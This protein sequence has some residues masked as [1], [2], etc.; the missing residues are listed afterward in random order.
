MLI[1]GQYAYKKAI[2]LTEQRMR[3]LHEVFLNYFDIIKYKAII[4]SGSEIEF[5]GINELVE[6][7]NHRE[8]KIRRIEV[9]CQKKGT[10]NVTMLFIHCH[11]DFFVQYDKTVSCLYSVTDTKE[12]VNL[13]NDIENIFTKARAKYW[14]FSKICT[15]Q[16]IIIWGILSLFHIIL[17]FGEVNQLNYSVAVWISIFSSMIFIVTVLRKILDSFLRFL[18]P[19]IV[20]CWGENHDAN[21]RGVALRSNISWGLLFAVVGAVIG[22]VVTKYLI[23]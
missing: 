8:R 1:K 19:P 16:L 18:F 11:T 4:E 3:D 15:I 13:K 2:I 21:T 10:F 22:G 9:T 23:K 14:I 17:N 20:F 7:D 6:F 12:E 5:N